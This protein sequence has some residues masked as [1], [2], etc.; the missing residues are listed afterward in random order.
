MKIGFRTIKTALGISIA[1][2]IAQALQL[3]YFSSAGI[4]TLL[5]IQKSRRKSFQAA[6]SRFFSCMLGFL[7]SSAVFLLIGFHPYAFLVLF[8]VFIPLCVRL[9][10]QEGLSSSLVI[11]MHVYMS[12]KIDVAFFMNELFVVT[13]GLGVALLINAY[14]PSSDKQLNQFKSEING[15]MS[16]ILKEIAAYLKDGNTL[17]DG[18][19]LLALADSLRKAKALALLDI[20]NSLQQRNDYYYEYFEKKQQ[21]YDVLERMLPHISHISI[22]LEQGARIGDF[23][24]K[25]SQHLNEPGH[26]HDTQD[27]HEQLRA[28]RDY[29]KLLPLPETREEFENRAS[30]FVVANQVGD[31]VYLIEDE[32]A[33]PEE[34][35][36]RR[37]TS[38]SAP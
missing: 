19:E 35:R 25:L 8:L 29:H 6:S 20:E 4:L 30:L 34:Q 12:Q 23:V 15:L 32:L 11:V 18:K 26:R 28:I 9:R 33:G 5:C 21:Q 13:I 3:E 27:Y 17:W 31:F 36:L 2:L 1:V 24:L 7:C 14:M 22:P 37:S 10:I 38:S 16:I